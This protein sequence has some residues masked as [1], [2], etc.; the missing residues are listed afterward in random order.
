MSDDCVGP[1]LRECPV[2]GA[3]GLPERIAVHDC[4]AFRAHTQG[5]RTQDAPRAMTD[6][7]AVHQAPI[8]SGEPSTTHPT[9][10]TTHSPDRLVK[11]TPTQVLMGLPLPTAQPTP[12]VHCDTCD[13]RLAEGARVTVRA[14]QQTSTNKWVIQRVYCRQCAP[15]PQTQPVC[16]AAVI[17]VTGSLGLSADPQTQQHVLCLTDL[18]QIAGSP[19]P[20]GPADA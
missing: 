10:E 14:A 8:S 13:T 20:E 2:C 15:T 9:T 5:Y 3:T 7:A 6:G 4:A 19:T 12:Y 1:A 16:T 11:A 17:W 18:A